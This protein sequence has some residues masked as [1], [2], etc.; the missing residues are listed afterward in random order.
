[1]KK[2]IALVLTLAALLFSAC[3]DENPVSPRPT[4]THP[5]QT[6]AKPEPEIYSVHPS[7]G[8]P[9]STVAILGANF[10]PALSN[11]YVMFGST[12]AE[13]TYVGYGVIRTRVPNLP[14]GDYEIYVT[15]DGQ[16]RRAPQMFAIDN[17]QH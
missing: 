5:A 10:G 11:N 6:N 7:A 12:S 4:P 2:Q 16:A 15:A 14:E 9:G 8:A 17:S 3:D 13:I 1:M